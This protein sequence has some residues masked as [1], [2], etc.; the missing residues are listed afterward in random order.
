MQPYCNHEMVSIS[1][2]AIEMST[3]TKRVTSTGE[4]RYRALLQIRREDVNYTESRTFSK[5]S[6]AEAWLKKREVELETNP[7]LLHQ[8]KKSHIKLN[9]TLAEVM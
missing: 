5:K 3:I 2:V 8:N 1:K 7:E 9:L 6:L 4:I